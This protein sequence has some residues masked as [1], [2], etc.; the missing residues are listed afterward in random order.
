MVREHAT[1]VP[2][3]R[4]ETTMSQCILVGVDAVFSL[5]THYAIEV[6][7]Q[8]LEQEQEA[9]QLLLLH[10]IPAVSLI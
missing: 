7:C 3:R 4:G 6:V 8:V 5:S 1:L 2:Q 10:V 9:C